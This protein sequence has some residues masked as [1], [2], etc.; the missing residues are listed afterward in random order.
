M[1]F[2]IQG[3][4]CNNSVVIIAKLRKNNTGVMKMNS[5]IIN[6]L[7]NSTIEVEWD[8]KKVWVAMDVAQK[9][10]YEN[11]SKVVNYF[12]TI[13][14]LLEGKDYEILSKDNLRSF[15]SELLRVG[16][17]KFSKSPKLVLFYESGLVK[18]LG[19]RNKL[20]NLEIAEVLGVENN[21]D[22]YIDISSNTI[23]KSFNGNEVYTLIWNGKPCWI[24]TDIAKV[25]EYKS[26]SMA[27]NQC[28]IS[29]EFDVGFDYDILMKKDIQK[30]L[31]PISH[32]LIGSGKHITQLTIF[33]KEGL[34]GFINYAHMPIG[35]EFRKWLRT[36]VF[37]ELIDLEVGST[38]GENKFS[39]KKDNLSKNDMDN[40]SSNLEN[41][42]FSNVLNVVD[43][44]LD[45]RDDKKINCV[46]SLLEIRKT[47]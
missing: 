6:Y 1:S 13:S 10:G 37:S 40:T 5:K 23:I 27:I 46:N 34:L 21:N 22:D 38:M 15:K 4:I 12:F 26:P 39:I 19:Y 2:K 36:E 32:L 9:L 45:E 3:V 7:K 11:P 42:E 16:I 24:A 44:I 31:E 25:M 43:K 30:C 18:F 28:I 17:D 35:K 20:S 14:G 8:G 41:L 47:I 29:E 33:Y